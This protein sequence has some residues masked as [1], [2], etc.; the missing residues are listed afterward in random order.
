M[1]ALFFAP[2]MLAACQTAPVASPVAVPENDAAPLPAYIFAPC[3]PQRICTQQYDPVCLVVEH[4]GRIFR[5][6]FSNTCHICGVIGK[7]VSRHRGE[8]GELQ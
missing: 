3:E 6:T 5:Q 4:E 1:K 8:C 7:V 2:L